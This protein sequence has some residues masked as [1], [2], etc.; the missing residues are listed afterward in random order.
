MKL[1]FVGG[2]TEQQEGKRQSKVVRKINGLKVLNFIKWS[3]FLATQL[4][5]NL[6]P[7]VNYITS[8]F[9]LQES[10][11][12]FDIKFTYSKILY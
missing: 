3:R 11:T 5:L 7:V 4:F 9:V 2:N 6:N 8:F 12:K 1:S 10:N